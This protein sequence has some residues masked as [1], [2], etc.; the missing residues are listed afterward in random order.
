[1]GSDDL[2]KKHKAKKTE[3]LK[4]RQ[5]KQAPYDRV[6]IVCE[7]E[8]TE[9]NYFEELREHYRLN[10]T[11]VK[12]TGD[13]GSSPISV[14]EKAIELYREALRNGVPFDR[15]YC[16]FDKDTHGTYDQAL[17]TIATLKPKN[18]FFAITSVPCFEYWL[19]LHFAYTTQPFR[20]TTKAKSVGDQVLDELKTYI[21]EYAKGDHGHF[22]ALLEQLSRAIAHAKQAMDEALRNGT[23]NPSTQVYELV[24]YLQG[25]RSQDGD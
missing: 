7:G 9:P 12:V 21:P 10:T 23:D 24:E 19:L 11:N 15:I 25:L 13:C 14:V 1:M 20:G 3:D 18:T 8:K 4:R 17:A 16:V 6:L 5:A 2:F 22:D